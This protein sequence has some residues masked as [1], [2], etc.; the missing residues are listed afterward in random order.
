MKPTT[1]RFAFIKPNPKL[2]GLTCV[3]I[4]PTE[5]CNRTCSFCP[6]HDPKLWPNQ[7]LQ[8][9]IETAELLR[10]NLDDSNFKGWVAFAGYGEPTLNPKILELIKVFKDYNVELITNG[11]NIL[12]DKISVDDLYDAGVNRLM[13]S[14]YDRNPVWKSF[15]DKY[16]HMIV[17]DHYDDGTDR[18]EEHDFNNRGGAQGLIDSPVQRPC[19]IPSYKLMF[20]WNGDIILCPVNW[21]VKRVINNINKETLSNIWM[22]EEFTGIRQKLIRGNRKDVSTCANC[23]VKGDIYGRQYADM[24]LEKDK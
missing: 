20:D 15:T 1:G 4:N 5:L 24:W 2:L 22:G 18:Y 3:E 23:D 16:P 9:T 17:R 8:M 21:T 19:F 11:D 12:K 6:R 7:N 10:S 14:D 13:V